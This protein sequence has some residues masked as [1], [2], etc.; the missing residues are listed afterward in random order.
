MCKGLGGLRPVN[1]EDE[2]KMKS[3]PMDWEG[4]VT[5]RHPRNYQFHKKYFALIK[6]G[7][8]NQE[9]YNSMDHYRILMQ[10][11]A[12]FYDLVTTDKG[13]LP[14]A[15]SISFSSMESHEFMDLYSK[16][17]YEISVHLDIGSSKLDEEVQYKLDGFN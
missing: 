16:V 8:E 10:M 5:L 2:E 1:T 14:I 13:V 15:K 6:L 4:E 3:L 12:G 17:L 9:Q 11:K 7:F